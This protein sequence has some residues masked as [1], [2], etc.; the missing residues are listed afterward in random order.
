MTFYDDNDLIDEAHA[1]V[2]YA[3]AAV[4]LAEANDRAPSD[5]GSAATLL[6]FGIIAHKAQQV[7]EAR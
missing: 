1:L 2:A 4:A 7:C 5:D 3:Q 6:V